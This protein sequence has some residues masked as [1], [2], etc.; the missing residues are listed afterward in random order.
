[1]QNSAY[2]KTSKLVMM[3][4][5]QILLSIVI[6][7][8]NGEKWIPLVAGSI[9]SSDLMLDEFEIVFVDD[10]SE[11]NT[12]AA[13]RSV[14]DAHSN[15]QVV[16]LSKHLCLGGGRNEGFKVAR[17]KYVWF[18]DA[19]D[20]IAPY[21]CNVA[22][23]KAVDENLDVLG[24]EYCVV[25]QK[26]NFIRNTKTY[27]DYNTKDGCAFA[28]QAFNSPLVD[29]IGFVWR[30]MYKNEYLQSA[31]L[32]FPIGVHWEDTVFMPA[33]IIGATKVGAIENV[34]YKYRQN[35]N[36]ISGTM[37]R[38]YPAEFIY[39]YAFVAGLDLLSYAKTINDTELEHAF[40]D[41]A[42]KNYI[43]GFL[44]YLLRTNRA[45]RRNFYNLVKRNKAIQSIK[46]YLSSWNRIL[47]TPCIGAGIVELMSA[48]YKLKH[49]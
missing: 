13:M 49:R 19:D 27:R 42:L 47:L 2:A 45:E 41:K 12:L 28:K 46:P 43:N 39:E 40:C 23:H 4:S 21:G 26:G 48:F 18:V 25:D 36:S 44:I 35:P 16:H 37:H 1:M 17:G 34:L 3:G 20:L 22:L 30:F 32:S 38:Q 33:T 6:P 11:D 9:Y 10:A 7:C 29:Q 14:A 8:R 31:Q 5:T 15:V 24:F